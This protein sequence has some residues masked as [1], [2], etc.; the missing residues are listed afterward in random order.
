V[1]LTSLGEKGAFLTEA[2]FAIGT[3]QEGLGK[4]LGVSR[5]TIIR[6]LDGPYISEDQLKTLAR[7]VYPH[8][9]ALAARLANAAGQTFESLGLVVP[10]STEPVR[11]SALPEHLV[12]SI[13]C[14]AAEANATT[15]QAIRPALLAAFERAFA[16]GLT[17]EQ[18]R[19][20]LRGDQLSP[21][22]KSAKGKTGKPAG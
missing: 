12:D 11:V 5:R 8:D 22:K 21:A 1:D 13:V 2:Q 18:V 15:P 3:S 6:W 20:V 17:V 16:V 14:A 4:L 10:P 7:A 19:G 9:K